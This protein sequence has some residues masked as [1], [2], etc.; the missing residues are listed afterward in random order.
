VNRNILIVAGEASGDNVGGLLSAELKRLRPELDLFGLGGDKMKSSGVDILFHI[1]QLSF[2]GFWEVVKHIPF[3]RKVEREVLNLIEMRKPSLAILIDYPG[4]N[5]RLAKKLKSLNVPILYYVS[6]QVWAWGK[7]RVAKI[8][9]LVDLMVVIFEFEKE[10]YDKAAVPVVWHGH[11]LLE[12]VKSEIS[13]KDLLENLGRSQDD[14][15]V[16]LFPGSRMQEIE[17]ILPVMRDVISRISTGSNLKGIVG[18]APGI[19]DTMYKKIGGDS[20]VYVRGMTYDL[21]THSELNLVASGTATLECAILGSPMFVL[22]KT[23]PLTYYLA[24][25]LINIPDIGLVNVV[26]GKRIVPEF[27]QGGCEPAA[28]A[29][30]ADRHL[31]HPE[32]LMNMKTELANIR[33]KLGAEGAS[34]KNAQTVLELIDSRT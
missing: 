32:V 26:A 30:E 17:R 4:F 21:M 6:P 18:C 25:S 31:S 11:P 27:V 9:E 13:K 16:G 20:L 33:Q 5:L 29:R 24:K 8:K 2:L 14:K 7:K 3:I 15:Y 23:S 1:N 12:I 28:I 22:Y 19:E 34:R 10:I